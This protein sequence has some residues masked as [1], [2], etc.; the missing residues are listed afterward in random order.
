VRIYL[1]AET[2]R[3][4]PQLGTS[5]QAVRAIIAQVAGA[6]GVGDVVVAAYFPHGETWCAKTYGTMQTPAT[7]H[8]AEDHWAIV[9]CWRAPS[10]LPRRFRL[11]RV[12]IGAGIV[13]PYES[14]DAYGWR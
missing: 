6:T 9:Q 7:W 2:M 5:P 12:W 3:T 10:D 4:L 13:Y 8:A 14:E 11:A 1:Y